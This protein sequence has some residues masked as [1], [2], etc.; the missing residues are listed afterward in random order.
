MSV[1]S[2]VRGGDDVFSGIE[3]REMLINDVAASKQ[4]IFV[5][6]SFLSIMSSKDVMVSSES[7]GRL[8]LI[9][10]N[11]AM[12]L[13]IFTISESRAVLLKHVENSIMSLVLA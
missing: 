6:K 11:L 12:C 10:F 13:S 5:C 7:L 8:P 4:S 3:L 2:G 9:V 1:E